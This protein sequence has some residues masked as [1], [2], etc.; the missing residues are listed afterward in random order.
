MENGKMIHDL[1]AIFMC[2]PYIYLKRTF[3]HLI[4]WWLSN[5]PK[6]E[7]QVGNLE[8]TVWDQLNLRPSIILFYAIWGIPRPVWVRFHHPGWNG[9]HGRICGRAGRDGWA[10]LPEGPGVAMR[11]SGT[12]CWR[13]D[14]SSLRQQIGMWHRCG[15]FG[16]WSDFDD[17]LG[18]FRQDLCIS[19][20]VVWMNYNIYNDLTSWRHWN[21]GK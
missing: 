19:L 2:F 17:V 13:A 5:S 4:V 21:D 15:E 11:G 6:Q 12:T 10:H 16:C 8:A 3:G 1:P 18:H 7:R 20:F 14:T 9:H